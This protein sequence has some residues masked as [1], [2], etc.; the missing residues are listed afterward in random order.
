MY[1]TTG[2]KTP[3]ITAWIFLASGGSNCLMIE[4]AVD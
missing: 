2:K 4:M 3:S 1:M